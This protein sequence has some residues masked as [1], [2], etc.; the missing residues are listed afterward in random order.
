MWV[1]FVVGSLLFSERFFSG[2]SGF[3]VSSKTNNYKFHFDPGMQG[4]FKRVLVN[5]WCSVGKQIAV[6]FTLTFTFKFTFT[7]E[8]NVKSE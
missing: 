7:M 1:D 5:S 6:T 8:E 2:Y 3:P 4:H